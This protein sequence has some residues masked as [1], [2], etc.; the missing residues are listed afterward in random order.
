VVIAHTCVVYDKGGYLIDG[1]HDLI[2][3]ENYEFLNDRDH[4]YHIRDPTF[5]LYFRSY[6]L[7]DTG[8]IVDVYTQNGTFVHTVRLRRYDDTCGKLVIDSEFPINIA[9]DSDGHRYPITTAAAGPPVDCLSIISRDADYDDAILP[10][11]DAY[12]RSKCLYAYVNDLRN[13]MWHMFGEDV[14]GKFTFVR[15]VAPA[16]LGGPG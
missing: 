12:L 9:V 7:P 3:M 2:E 1:R 4:R 13:D 15:L 10:S 14:K 5:T 11:W 16:L 6:L 8:D